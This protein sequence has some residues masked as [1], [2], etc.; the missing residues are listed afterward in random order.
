MSSD[1]I[2]ISVRNLKKVYRVYDNPLQRIRQRFVPGK[3]KYYREFTALDG[4]SFDIRKGETVGIIGR[5]GSGKSTLL[6]LM[7]GILKPSA[8][9]V[10]RR[11]RIAA[12]LELGAGFHPEFTGRE[13]VFMQGAIMGIP[14]R[15]M[16]Q[17][18]DAIA[19]FAEIGEHMEQP[20]KAYSSGMFLRLAFA[21]AI[22]V[23]PD[24][25]VVDEAMAV[26]DA[27]FQKRCYAKIRQMQQNGLTL[28]FV[29]HDHE[30]VRTL[31]ERALLLDRGKP[32]FLGRTQ[33]A[34]H[35]YRKMLFEQ[36]A[37]YWSDQIGDPARPG[38]TETGGDTPAYGIGGARIMGMRILG[39]N[40]EPRSTFSLGER[41]HFEIAVLVERPLAQLNVSLVI[42]TLQGLK[43][44]SWG[45]F[46]QDISI[47]AGKAEG[48]IFWDRSFEQG[49]EIVV[50]LTMEGNLGTGNYEVQAV[51][52]RELDKQYGS[53]QVLH[54]RDEMGFFRVVADPREYIFG[55][56]CDLRGRAMLND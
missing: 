35:Y 46:N 49:K 30:L 32:L 14:R 45:T 36:E 2:M 25:L 10:E 23:E 15:Q 53:Q 37:A 13:N 18:F 39:T 50:T 12:L 9:S 6:Q 26:G 21:V 54:W 43:V 20:I 56:V 8:G 51:V 40:D 4:V 5:N 24:I 7:C 34:T 11:G 31:T 42:R 33:E 19:A 27:Q 22:H 38:A 29:S 47:W 48:E 41:M 17:S 44:Y 28:I 52:S 55:G 16:E 3:R 1:E